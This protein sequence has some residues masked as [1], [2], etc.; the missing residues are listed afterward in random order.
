MPKR[1]Y[2]FDKRQKDLNKKAKREE[3]LRRRQERRALG[4]ADPENPDEV[5]Y[6]E[7]SESGESSAQDPDSNA[8]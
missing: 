7:S 8:P 6:S 4:N 1:N 3:K 5:P 2:S